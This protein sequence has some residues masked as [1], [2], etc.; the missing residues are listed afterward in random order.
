MFIILT[1]DERPVEQS[2]QT[3]HVVQDS[4]TVEYS[5]YSLASDDIVCRSI[6]HSDSQLSQA[7]LQESNK[8]YLASLNHQQARA[9]YTI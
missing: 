3:Y 7:D 5:T 4:K 9:T 1:V 2:K 6:S 8:E